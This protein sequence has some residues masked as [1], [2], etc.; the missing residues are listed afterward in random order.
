MRRTLLC[1]TASKTASCAACKSTLRL[2]TSVQRPRVKLRQRVR[3]RCAVAAPSRRLRN[4]FNNASQSFTAVNIGAACSYFSC[5]LNYKLERLAS[6]RPP[7][8]LKVQRAQHNRAS[9]RPL[10][11]S[12]FD[13]RR[14]VLRRREFVMRRRAK[15]SLQSAN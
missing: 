4:S 13:I 1:L 12:L 3:K 11:G 2:Q 15:S 7:G 14:A 5:A 10:D 6:R 8:P 9:F